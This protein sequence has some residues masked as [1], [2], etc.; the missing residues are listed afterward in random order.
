MYRR[1]CTGTTH[2][3]TDDV[4]RVRMTFPDNDRDHKAPFDVG[5][6]VANDCRIYGTCSETHHRPK[7][8]FCL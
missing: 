3:V 4:S 7:N 5:L 6:G 2:V 1:L 8:A